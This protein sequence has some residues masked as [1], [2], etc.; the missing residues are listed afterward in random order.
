MITLKNL[1]YPLL[2]RLKNLTARRLF[3]L[4]AANVLCLVIVFG[5]VEMLFSFLPHESAR[6]EHNYFNS[7]SAKA[8]ESVPR[9][10]D[11]PASQHAVNDIDIQFAIKAHTITTRNNAF[12][13]A[14]EN[15]GIRLE[16]DPTDAQPTIV[17]GTGAWYVGF[18]VP[19]SFEL[20]RTYQMRIHIHKGRIKC[21]LDDKE[22]LSAVDYSLNYAVD[23]VVVGAGF[24]QGRLFDGE[25]SG[26]VISYRAAW[27]PFAIK[28]LKILLL[29]WL[30]IN[31]LLLVWHYKIVL[32]VGRFLFKDKP[33]AEVLPSVET[34]L[35]GYKSAVRGFLTDIK[36]I[37]SLLFI[38]TIG[39]AYRL[40]HP[41][42]GADDTCVDRYFEDNYLVAQFRIT[43]YIL[44]KI[45]GVYTLKPFVLD[46]MSVVMLVASALVF[47]AVFKMASRSK[48]HPLTYTIFSCLFV[49]FP[50]LFE[51]FI[52]VGGNLNICMGYLLV[53]IALIFARE[54]LETKR[55]VY[56]YLAAVVTYFA[57]ACYESF[58]PVYLCAI[59]ILL[60]LNYI[61]GESD[62]RR[63][64]RVV[65]NGFK[66]LLPLFAAVGIYKVMSIILSS[67]VHLPNYAATGIAWSSAGFSEVFTGLWKGM[68]L[69]FVFS[70]LVFQPITSLVIAMVSCVVLMIV[71]VA[72]YR[73]VA[74]VF[75]LLAMLL[76]LF[77]LSVLQ[78][79]AS[80]YRYCQVFSLF[81][82]FIISL[83]V[84]QIISSGCRNAL[85][86]AVL[87]SVSV[88]IFRQ[89]DDLSGWFHVD[90]MRAEEEQAMARQIAFQIKSEFPAYKP[91]LF[92]GGSGISE[93]V[94]SY[95]IIK[96]ATWNGRAFTTVASRMMGSD[97]SGYKFV[98]G[99]MT[100]IYGWAIGAFGEVN[101]E[102]LKY[103]RMNGHTFKQGS[104]EMFVEAIALSQSKPVWPAKGSIFQTPT[105]VVVHL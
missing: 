53:S 9:T 103:F 10:L 33:S 85:K 13:T 6:A 56:F 7:G 15:I 76:S 5:V 67:F 11:L 104:M 34:M 84:H 81:A 50:L 82:G 19:H 73:K 32:L 14:D 64:G 21:F 46:F 78:G 29:S 100:P 41:A 94:N 36:Y 52:V 90:I 58:A 95:L 12:Q 80:F 39:F 48:L 60:A 1:Q 49:S 87:V 63:M 4:L 72:K 69:K 47:S 54:M 2:D 97:M 98:E 62:D 93:N 59:C 45:L 40:V 35:S 83:L 65:T 74:I 37:L 77:S 25:I 27:E 68:V 99:D 88:L 24:S 8:T 89:A 71:Y 30:A 91:V 75:I 38:V 55:K 43:G 57:L 23:K 42:I 16:F 17:V 31:F 26:F 105:Y 18:L 66:L 28:A 51:I 102:L 70:G 101:A 20:N 96:P 61:F 3:T 22:V 79:Y 86:N 92:T 44:H